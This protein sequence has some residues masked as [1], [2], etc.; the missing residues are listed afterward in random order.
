MKRWVVAS[1]VG[2]AFGA[3]AAQG[4]DVI[5]CGSAASAPAGTGQT[6][7]ALSDGSMGVQQVVHLTLVNGG[8]A[9]DVPMHGGAAAGLKVGA[10]MLLVFAI[11][12]GLRA[13]R[14]F[15]E[16]ASES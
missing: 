14:R 12:Y 10:A 11:A 3:R 2:V 1:L 8:A 4:I 15:L 7:C 5:V 6:P 16:S 13:L 9:D